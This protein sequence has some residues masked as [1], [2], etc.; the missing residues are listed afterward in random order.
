MLYRRNEGDVTPA[1]Y[2][3]RVAAEVMLCDRAECTEGEHARFVERAV[4]SATEKI[5]ERR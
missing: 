4:A 2:L 5:Q 1:E 3:G